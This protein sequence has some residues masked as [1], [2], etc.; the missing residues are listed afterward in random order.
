M[1]GQTAPPSP[2]CWEQ[3]SGIRGPG[4]KPR[5]HHHQVNPSPLSLSLLF[6][7]M[8]AGAPPPPTIVRGEPRTPSRCLSHLLL[9]LLPCRSSVPTASRPPTPFRAARGEE[10]GQR[11]VPF[12]PTPAPEP[13]PVRPEPGRAGAREGGR[14]VLAGKSLLGSVPSPSCCR[15]PAEGVAW[16]NVLPQLASTPRSCASAA[17]T[18]CGRTP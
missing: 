5:L 16:G 11:W 10:N 1:Q 4:F 17:S 3:S 8:G 14:E 9:G 6:H 15:S 18:A 12:L 2:R 13:H 7:Q